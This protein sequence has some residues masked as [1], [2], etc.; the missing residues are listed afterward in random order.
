MSGPSGLSAHWKADIEPLLKSRSIAVVGAS[1]R[2]RG[3]RVIESLRTIGFGGKIYP[4][5]QKY[6]D[7]L[8]LRCYSSILD[9]DDEIDCAAIQIPAK[10]VLDV[11][12]QCAEKNIKA[13]A[14]NTAGFSETHS[15]AGQ[16]LQKQLIRIAED[17][18]I[19]VCGPNCMGVVSPCNRFAIYFLDLASVAKELL[20]GSLAIV[21]QSGSLM[22]SILHTG[23]LAGVSFS[24]LIS[25]GNE[26]VLEVSNY[27]EYLVEDPHTRVIGLVVEGFRDT[28]NVRRVAAAALERE[29]PIII[30]KLGRSKKGEETTLA[31]TGAL[32]GTD[33]VYEAFFKK[34]GWIRVG[35]VDDFLTTASA[36]TK[37]QFPQGPRVAVLGS[38]GGMTAL[39][40]DLC[41]EFGLELPDLDAPTAEKVNSALPEFILAKNPLDMGPPAPDTVKIGKKC[42]E[43]LADSRLFDMVVSVS[44]QAGLGSIDR[45]KA[46]AEVAREKSIPFATVLA[47]S[48]PLTPE[49]Q[50]LVREEDSL[51]LQ[52]VRRAFRAVRR[53]ADYGKFR[54]ERHWQKI[55]GDRPGSLS[56]LKEWPS[57][58][59]ILG[60]KEAKKLLSLYDIPIVREESAS[61][62]PAA[63]AA[64]EGIGYPVV[65]KIDSPDIAHKTDVG[66]VRLRIRSPRELEFAYEEVLKATSTNAPRARI[67][68]VLIQEMVENG[69][70]MILGMHQDPQFGP[71]LLCG[72]GGVLAEL[73]QDT[74]LRLCPL[75]EGD[76][77]AMLS[78]LKGFQVLMGYRGGGKKDLKSV[79]DVL[80]GLSCLSLD[81]MSE[82]ETIDINPLMVFP[83][84]QG[85]KVADALIVRHKSRLGQ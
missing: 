2:G 48:E 76:A 33:A 66:G 35:D 82:I 6:R 34:F 44:S 64:A 63:L 59:G 20:L 61:N 77:E 49:A 42:V 71:V 73:L 30:L 37:G 7:V 60:E 39:C 80:H 41:E 25:T 56:G 28:E 4:V 40:A 81:F 29:K 12:R 45:H 27:L 21:S 1:E 14:I 19:R 69:L 65:L 75:D 32:A 50:K 22:M 51:L 17:A 74:S 83:D 18:Q 16:N 23:T 43:F 68:G 36:F 78:E 15:E 26:A 13:M 72:F 11:V 5:N 47:T 54:A 9:I 62:L 46:A 10:G 31:H 8:G 70:E 84:G 57:G 55:P 58:N 24:H 53:L 38:S 52:D 79:T 85:V 67:E 3:P